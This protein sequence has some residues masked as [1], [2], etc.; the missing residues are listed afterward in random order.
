MAQRCACG[1]GEVVHKTTANAAI[2][3]NGKP[4]AS[5]ICAGKVY[6]A[7]PAAALVEYRTDGWG[8]VLALSTV[9][10]AR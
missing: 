6:A 1:C 3:A 4:C 9:A 10:P 8:D 2:V 5:E 7:L